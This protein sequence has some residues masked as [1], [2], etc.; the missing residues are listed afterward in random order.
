M[1]DSE[2]IYVKYN[3]NLGSYNRNKI[4]TKDSEIKNTKYRILNYDQDVICDNDQEYGN[5]RSIVLDPT[6]EPPKILSFSPPKSLTIQHFKD[7]YPKIDDS[8]LVNE[9]VEGTMINLFYDA[10]INSWEISTK[11][12]VGGNYWFFRNEYPNIPNKMT[13]SQLTFRRMFLEALRCL[14]NMDLN[15]CS[16]L[17]ELSK[18]YCYCFVMQHPSNHIV[19]YIVNPILYLVA[20]YH[21]N[22]ENSQQE[23]QV[24]SIPPSVFE[25]WDCFVNVRG[26]IEFPKRFEEE[27]YNELYDNYCSPNASYN[28][29]GIMFLNIGSGERACMENEAYKNVRELRG[30]HPNLQYQYLCLKNMGKVKEFLRYFPNYKE[31]FYH[32]YKQYTD[33]ITDTH[34]SY[35]SYYVQKSGIKISKKFF[36]LIYNIHH[37]LFLP[38]KLS[39]EPIIVRRQVVADY[40]GKLSPNVL[41]YYLN[42]NKK[43]NAMEGNDASITAFE[44]SLAESS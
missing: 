32:F 9:I 28:S 7:K 24:T 25:E 29:V 19:N 26:I 2:E 14:P 5:Y 27:D 36:P 4:K 21:I 10:R 1:D 39:G 37:E 38:A 15:D 31:I 11:G 23:S 43:E 20:V 13:S 42:Y 3:L 44:E 33:F 35:I 40:V 30:N 16:F 8:I 6:Q 18:E 34:Q 22:F 12:A 41:L 17:N